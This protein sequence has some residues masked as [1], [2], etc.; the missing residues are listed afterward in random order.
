MSRM[1]EVIVVYCLSSIQLVLGVKAK[2]ER[3]QA[4][5]SRLRSSSA[6]LSVVNRGSST[7][8]RQWARPASTDAGERSNSHKPYVCAETFSKTPCG[9]QHECRQACSV[10]TARVAHS[11]TA[12]TS[13]WPGPLVAL[14]DSTTGTGN[15]LSNA[16]R[17]LVHQLGTGVEGCRW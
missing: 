3:Q 12:P 5:P 6:T 2:L 7:S 17:S 13:D 9:Q 8:S 14:C 16:D 15:A 10:E 4:R 1:C 11:D